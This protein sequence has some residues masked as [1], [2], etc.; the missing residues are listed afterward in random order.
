M[1]EMEGGSQKQINK[2]VKII[3]K[4]IPITSRPLR[5]FSTP[6]GDFS[7]AQPRNEYPKRVWGIVLYPQIFPSFPPHLTAPLVPSKLR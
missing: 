4:T 3:F 7:Y 6:P 5:T 2:Q 1:R